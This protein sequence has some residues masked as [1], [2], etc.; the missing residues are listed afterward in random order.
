MS[1]E[2]QCYKSWTVSFFPISEWVTFFFPPSSKKFTERAY[3]ENYRTQP[4]GDKEH[5][6]FRGEGG[7]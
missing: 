2:K 7:G 4:E 3:D 5:N 1:L 6:K